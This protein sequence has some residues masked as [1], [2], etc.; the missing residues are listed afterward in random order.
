[1]GGA[2]DAEVPME[3]P[4]GRAKAFGDCDNRRVG[5]PEPQVGV[6]LDQRRDAPPVA[7]TKVFDAKGTVDDRSV[8]GNLGMRH[9][10]GGRSDRQPLRRPGRW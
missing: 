9:K 7:G 5:A 3:W 1:M 6:L 10:A 4:P 2:N 8:Q